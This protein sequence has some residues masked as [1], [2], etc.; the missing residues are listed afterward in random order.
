MFN[1]KGKHNEATIK[2]LTYNQD[3]L[4]QVRLLCNQEYL[5]NSKIV[6]MP[7]CHYS[8]GATVGTTITYSDKVSPMVVGSDLGCGVLLC[9][10]DVKG[11]GIDYKTLDE[12]IKNNVKSG[13]YNYKELLSRKAIGE[14]NKLRCGFNE[15]L[16]SSLGELGGGNHFIELSEDSNSDL[17]LTIHSGS[18]SIGK[19]VYDYYSSLS[20]TYEYNDVSYK[21][22]NYL[23]SKELDNYIYDVDIAQAVAQENRLIIRDIILKEMGWNNISTKHVK[24]NY[25][26]IHNK[27]IRKGAISAQKGELCIIPLNMRDGC[28][29]G[30]GKGNKDW[31]YSAPHGSGRKY[32]RS[33]SKGNI[34]IDEFKDSMK[35]VY[36]SGVNQSNVDESPM[37]YKDTVEIIDLVSETID[38]EEVIKPVYNYKS[39]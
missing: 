25:I 10:L 2:A 32:S 9:K 4:E 35:N 18:R 8:N 13:Y 15:G 26:D 38:I 16:L 12:T 21:G 29:I 14:L 28:I 34:S 5:K 36:S 6:L 22:L 31:N 27:I 39:H 24:H 33:Q 30:Y 11:G 17:Y 20:K 1:V 19:H 37:A 23:K 7:D 3:T